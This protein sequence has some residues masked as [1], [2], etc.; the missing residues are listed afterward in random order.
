MSAKDFGRRASGKPMAP[1]LAGHA[2]TVFA[3]NEMGLR[4]GGAPIL[5]NADGVRGIDRP[6]RGCSSTSGKASRRGDSRRGLENGTGKFAAGTGEA[7]Q[8]PK[9][10]G[11]G[12][13][14]FAA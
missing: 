13:Q 1:G 4:D 12:A 10:G 2:L 3:T 9:A 5:G 8:F 14:A 7:A 11:S 6:R